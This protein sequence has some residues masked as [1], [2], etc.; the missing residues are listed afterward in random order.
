MPLSKNK[1]G[2]TKAYLKDKGVTRNG[3]VNGTNAIGAGKKA[4]AE[5]KKTAIKQQ[6]RA[7]ADAKLATSRGLG[8]GDGSWNRKTESAAK[9][10]GKAG[11]PMNGPSVA[12]GGSSARKTVNK[13]TAQSMEARPELKGKYK[14]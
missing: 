12:A 1:P 14:P 10:A 3:E 11:V 5:L 9:I 7:S 13:R 2:K 6:V 8:P 4:K